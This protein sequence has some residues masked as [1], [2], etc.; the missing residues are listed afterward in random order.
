VN[1]PA[2]SGSSLQLAALSWRSLADPAWLISSAGVGAGALLPLLTPAA[3]VGLSVCPVVQ[4]RVQ[5]RMNRRVGV[6]LSALLL[7]CPKS[8]LQQSRASS[9]SVWADEVNHA[10]IVVVLVAAIAAVAVA[11]VAPM[12][13]FV[14]AAVAAAL[15]VAAVAAALVVAAVAAALAAVVPVVVVVV[16]PVVVAALAVAAVVDAVAPPTAAVVACALAPVVVELAAAVA[17]AAP[18]VAALADVVALAHVA[19]APA[20][21]HLCLVFDV[22]F[23]NIVSSVQLCCA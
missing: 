1:S 10:S 15:V 13:A 3:A 18:V 9:P 14:A 4:V 12:A 7:L 6:S 22:V 8:D 2:V 16:V 20:M 19:A 17:L 23:A 21:G 11:V 5:A